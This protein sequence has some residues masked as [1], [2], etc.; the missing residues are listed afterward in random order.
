V[1]TAFFLKS[2]SARYKTIV[3]RGGIKLE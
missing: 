3:E 1:E 2:E